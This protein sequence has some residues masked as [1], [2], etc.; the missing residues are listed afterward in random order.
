MSPE[1]QE[2][3]SRP[4]KPSNFSAIDKEICSSFSLLQSVKIDDNDLKHYLLS[5][6]H[7]VSLLHAKT[8]HTKKLYR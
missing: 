1:E 5:P 3:E 8:G 6:Y 2:E 4:N 7:W